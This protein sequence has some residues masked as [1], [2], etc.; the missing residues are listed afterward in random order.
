M[1]SDGKAVLRTSMQQRLKAIDQAESEVWAMEIATRLVDEV[2][3]KS[4]RTIMAYLAQGSELNLDPAIA[5]LLEQGRTVAVPE[6]SETGTEMRPIKL[7]TLCSSALDVDRF[8][9]RVPHLRHEIDTRDLDV[10]IIPGVAFDHSGA[11][12]GRGGGFYDRFLK[13]LPD[14][15]MRVGACFSIQLL[16]QIPTDSHD[17]PMGLVV[18]ERGIHQ[19]QN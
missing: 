15:T 8:G 6:V 14:G 16:E 19:A 1:S 11:R 4:A 17:H 2:I 3:P 13:S 5:L 7:D 9:I 18:T 12:L 10:L